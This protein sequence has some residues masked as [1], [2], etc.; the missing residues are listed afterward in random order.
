MPQGVGADDPGRVLGPPVVAPD[1]SALVVSLRTSTANQ[2][3]IR[4]LNANQLIPIERTQDGSQPFWSPDSQHIAFFAEGKLKR[5]PA[6]GGSVMVLCEAQRPRGGSWGSRGTIIFGLNTHAIFQVA[7][8]GGPVK[9]VNQLD[10]AWGE[11]SHR[12]PVFL[13]DGD[14]F[15][16]LARNDNPD[17]QGI[18]LE[19][20]DHSVQRKKILVAEGAFALGHDPDTQEHFLLSQQVGKIVAQRFDIRRGTLYGQP[21]RLVNRGG[22]LSA[23]NTGVLVMRT[24]Q[25]PSGLVWRDRNGT[26]IG[27]LGGATEFWAVALSPNGQFV[28]A[29]KHDP[30]NG[31]FTVWVASLTDGLF[32]LV[33]DADHATSVM[34]S[35]DS[36]TIYY[37]DIRE[38]K[39][40]RRT[41]NPRGVEEV[42]CELPRDAGVLDVS[43]DGRYA[44]GE[45]AM[46]SAHTETA[47]IDLRS[48]DRGNPKSDAWHR[49]GSSDPHGPLPRFSPDGKWLAFNSTQGG[50]AEVYVMDFPACLQRHR[51]STDG[52]RDPRWRNDCKELFYVSDDGSLMAVPVSTQGE[53]QLGKP[54][55]LFAANLRRGGEGALYDVSP[56]GQRF[57]LI[58]AG[59]DSGDSGIEMILNW[60][61]LL[62]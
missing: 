14:R 28:A 1:G 51:V 45:L 5:V 15:L 29:S 41:L 7:E 22:M 33:S 35:W 6:A 25:L 44:A 61:S 16:Y 55:R 37:A 18:Y 3:Y 56:N 20:I 19:S 48:V 24:E 50:T 9:A 4:P 26:K 2:L 60:P 58:A 47:W 40:F 21:H 12:F 54:D 32:E 53:L 34:W 49:L 10:T 39:L 42:V 23:S 11:N 59:D 8:S 17:R 31:Q 27:V 52:G 43:P 62:L 38:W 13:P 36:N 30:I 46:L 57:L